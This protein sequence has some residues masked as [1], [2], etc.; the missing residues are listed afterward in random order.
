LEDVADDFLR[1]TGQFERRP[2]REGQEQHALGPHALQHE[3]RDAV[4]QGVGLAGAGARDDQQR[5]IAMGRGGPLCGI[6]LFQ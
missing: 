1:A 4:R 6:E 5:R 3:M 2:A